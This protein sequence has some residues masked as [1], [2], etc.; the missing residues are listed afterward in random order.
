MRKPTETGSNQDVAALG[1]LCNKKKLTAIRGKNAHHTQNLLSERTWEF[2]SPHP[3][4]RFQRLMRLL[5][6]TPFRAAG[7]ARVA[8]DLDV[9]K[10][11]SV[12]PTVKKKAREM[13]AEGE[14]LTGHPGPPAQPT[15]NL[16]PR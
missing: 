11:A 3:H 14:A 1:Q 2:E 10:I 15:P 12:L 9:E 6:N 4:Q 8:A 5:P 13:Q 16:V 7:Y